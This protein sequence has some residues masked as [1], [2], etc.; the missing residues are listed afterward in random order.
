M[1]LQTRNDSYHCHASCPID[2]AL[3]GNA[4]R[5]NGDLEKSPVYI[6]GKLILRPMI[7]VTYSFFDH[8]FQLVKQPF[9]SIDAIASR[10]LSFPPGAAAQP[11]VFTCKGDRCNNERSNGALPQPHEKI[12][13]A[14]RDQQEQGRGKVGN[15]GERAPRSAPTPVS[16]QRGCVGNDGERHEC[17]TRSSHEDEEMP[18]FGIADPSARG[19]V[20]RRNQNAQ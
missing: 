2:Y 14:P 7:D 8:F 16:P 3:P 1:S 9:A 17:R 19:R 10:L 4:E 12:F 13:T 11:A 18:A 6:V 20:G 5:P 15:D